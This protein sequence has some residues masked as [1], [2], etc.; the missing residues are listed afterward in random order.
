MTEGKLSRR[1]FLKDLSLT[2]AG[3]SLCVQMLSTGHAWGKS[4]QASGAKNTITMKYRTLGRTGLKVSALSFGV[5]RLTEPAVLFQ[6]LDMGIN[7]FD[8]AHGYQN[9]NNEK[10]LG[11]VLKQYGRQKVL[12]ATKIPPY[13]RRLGLKL[14]N[15]SKSMETK[16]E[17]SLRRLQTDHVDVLLLHNIAEPD[18]P[19]NDEMLGFCQKMKETGKARFVGISFHSAGQTFVDT[20]DRALGPDVYDVFL[21]TLNYK[22]PPEHIEALKRAHNKN[23]GIVA[24]KTQAGGY[25][26]QGNGSLNPHQAAL[27]W[28]LDCTFVDCAIPGMVNL[29]QLA[30]NAGVM[31]TKIGWS[32]RKTLAA[33]YN[34]VK[35]R[36]CLRCGS[37]TASCKKGVEISTIHRSLM[38]WEG[39][40]DF[41]LGRATYRELSP[42][43]NAL[44]CMTCLEPTCNCINGIKISERMYHAH[45]NFT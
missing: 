21:A 19:V 7:Y 24:M 25:N 39:Y 17:E 38:Y 14:L 23:V 42:T 5:M 8:T 30:E 44:E 13:V 36:Y 28:V 6:A 3:G 29:Q 31:E 10:M 27:K 26:S 1:R 43:E 45:V 35:D 9:G 2:C 15:D 18:W 40:A 4:H 34:A 22:S 20:V 37:C 16:M 12:I 41:D 33:Y 32:D 11:N